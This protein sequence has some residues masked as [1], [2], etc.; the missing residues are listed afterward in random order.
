[1]RTFDTA[2]GLRGIGAQNFRT[3]RLVRDGSRH[4]TE[5]VAKFLHEGLKVGLVEMGAVEATYRG[6]FHRL[7][8]AENNNP[9][10]RALSLPSNIRIRPLARDEAHRKSVPW[11]SV[12]PA[13]AAVCSI[14][15]ER[16]R[17]PGLGCGDASWQNDDLPHLLTALEIPPGRLARGIELGAGLTAIACACAFSES[18]AAL[19]A[20]A[21]SSPSRCGRARH[22]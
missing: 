2:L 13:G 7:R 6:R 5:P 12:E 15:P 18:S 16:R 9:S 11:A 1:M 4:V 3:T 8:S 22:E 14:R 19:N 21:G 17:S 20:C 10:A